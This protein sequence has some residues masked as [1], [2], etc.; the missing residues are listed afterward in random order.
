MY[1]KKFGRE[2]IVTKKN[3]NKEYRTPAK[4]LNFMLAYGGGADKLMTMLG[5]NYNEAVELIQLY[6]KTFPAIK[7][8]LDESAKFAKYNGYSITLPPA[9]RIRW[10]KDHAIALSYSSS[11]DNQYIARIERQGKNARIQGCN[12]DITKLALVYIHQALKGTK[13]KIVNTVHD[14]IVCEFPKSFV[15]EGKK[16]QHDC[17]IKAAQEFLKTV[18]MKVEL[19]VS[20]YWQK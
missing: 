15:E 4:N 13:G 3:E 5:V 1:S 8:S 12:A 9:E 16:I 2:F 7:K 17:M 18:P 6:Y 19:T 11:G 20:K 14:E 10:Y